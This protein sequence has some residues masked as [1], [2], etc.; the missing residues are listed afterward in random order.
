[1]VPSA[2]IART[3]RKGRL[4]L[5]KRKSSVNTLLI[6]V[7]LSPV[8]LLR[9]ESHI[10]TRSQQRALAVL[11]VTPDGIL[12]QTQ[13][14]TRKQ[15][16]ETSSRLPNTSENIAL[17]CASILDNQARTWRC[18]RMKRTVM[19]ERALRFVSWLNSTESRWVTSGCVEQLTLARAC[20]YAEIE[21]KEW[22]LVIVCYCYCEIRR[23]SE[24]IVKR[25]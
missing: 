18:P 4:T 25:Y 7:I 22:I 15:T 21:R 12:M 20:A 19:H 1:M 10:S 13:Q 2:V 14:E 23:F 24:W 5:E 17:K 8:D 3:V 11:Q 16:S 6:S 9:D